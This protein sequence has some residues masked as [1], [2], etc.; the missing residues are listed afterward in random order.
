[1]ASQMSY[2]KIQRM[3]RVGSSVLDCI[4]NET[5]DDYLTGLQ[6]HRGLTDHQGM[7]FPY[8]DKTVTFHMG[9]VSFPIDILFFDRNMS[10]AKIVVNAQ[11]GTTARW[12]FENCSGVLEVRGGWCVTHGVIVGTKAR[13]I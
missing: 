9:T 13:W 11:P 2:A 1:M 3:L 8:D 10:V 6:K 4:V 5:A 12:T 7:F